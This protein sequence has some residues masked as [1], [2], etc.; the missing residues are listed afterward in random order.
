MVDRARGAKP[1]G[2]S[3]L[4]SRTHRLVYFELTLNATGYLLLGLPRLLAQCIVF[5]LQSCDDLA[6]ATSGDLKAL[7]ILLGF[8]AGAIHFPMRTIL[9]FAEMRLLALPIFMQGRAPIVE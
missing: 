3:E 1:V 5:F 8:P 6:A 9:D 7:L 4:A 2:R